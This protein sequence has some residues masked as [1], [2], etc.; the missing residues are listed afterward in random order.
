MSVILIYL[1]A[2]INFPFFNLFLGSVDR[3]IFNKVGACVLLLI[4][5]CKFLLMSRAR[6]SSFICFI[7]SALG[8]GF[9]YF[10]YGGIFTY[11]FQNTDDYFRWL[12]SNL[13]SFFGILSFLLVIERDELERF[14]IIFVTFSI[15]S[16]LVIVLYQLYIGVP[17]R[18]WS[19]F[20]PAS[21]MSFPVIFISYSYLR[22]YFV[23]WISVALSGSARSFILM[24]LVQLIK[25]RN[26][27]INHVL[28]MTLMFSLMSIL[29]LTEAVRSFDSLL[30]SVSE[31]TEIGTILNYKLIN[32]EPLAYSLTRYFPSEYSDPHSFI[33]FVASSFGWLISFFFIFLVLLLGW[34][35]WF[36]SVVTLSIM[37]SETI[38]FKE[39]GVSAILFAWLIRY[40]YGKLR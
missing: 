34:R 24:I 13:T 10:G 29:V 28:L 16:A 3:Y 1:I 25:L 39:P 7:I 19:V 21:I 14:G 11:E 27:S 36:M 8:L 6:V 26:L 5:F 22:G 18:A 33:I 17:T 38:I 23:G 4:V 9:L 32:F 35:N 15:L 2:F 20:G 37:W 30:R 12:M 40:S 31:R